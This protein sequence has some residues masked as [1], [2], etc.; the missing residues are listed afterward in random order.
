MSHW[1]AVQRNP[2]PSSITLPQAGQTRGKNSEAISLK[3]ENILPFSCL[4]QLKN[5][6]RMYVASHISIQNYGIS[7]ENP[8][9]EPKLPEIS[10]KDTTNF[11]SQCERGKDNKNRYLCRKKWN[12]E[13]YRRNKS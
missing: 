6:P 13:S 8:H 3:G 9:R 12:Y 1:Q 10:K 11:Y 4:N 5:G 2:A 7:F